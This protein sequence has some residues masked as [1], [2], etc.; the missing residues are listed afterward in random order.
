MTIFLKSLSVCA[1][2]KFLS[3]W[4][5]LYCNVGHGQIWVN[6][7]PF[8]EK[9]SLRYHVSIGNTHLSTTST[10]GFKKHWKCLSLYA[11]RATAS[12]IAVT[13]SY[14]VIFL[15]QTNSSFVRGVAAQFCLNKFIADIVSFFLCVFVFCMH[16]NVFCVSIWF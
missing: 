3:F 16:M 10:E 9:W 8:K 13:C 11:P 4:T 15:P 12:R 2:W 7:H 1:Q 5:I 14:H 6:L